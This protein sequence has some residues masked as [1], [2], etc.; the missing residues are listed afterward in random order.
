MI[1][2]IDEGNEM[3]KCKESKKDNSYVDVPVNLN[4]FFLDYQEK[5]VH[6]L[7]F[8]PVFEHKSDH[9]K[10]SEPHVL[11]MLRFLIQ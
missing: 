8:D 5:I 9:A 10:C 2:N 11:K 1:I 4:E 7:I 3:I 6:S